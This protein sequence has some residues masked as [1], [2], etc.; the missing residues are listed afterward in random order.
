M[1]R[2]LCSSRRNA[3]ARANPPI[4]DCDSRGVAACG[5]LSIITAIGRDDN[6][7]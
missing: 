7:A 6:A 2:F 4:T 1:G 5:G 3:Q